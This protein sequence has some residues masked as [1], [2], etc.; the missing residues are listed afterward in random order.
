MPES[1]ERE[2]NS[3][4]TAPLG[5]DSLGPA[6]PSHGVPWSPSAL[7]PAQHQDTACSWTQGKGIPWTQAVPPTAISLFQSSPVLEVPGPADCPHVAPVDTAEVP[8]PAFCKRTTVTGQVKLHSPASKPSCHLPSIKDSS[9]GAQPRVLQGSHKAT[10]FPG[11]MAWCL[12]ATK[13]SALGEAKLCLNPGLHSDT[14]Q[15]E[16]THRGLL[17]VPLSLSSS[18]FST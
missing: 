11:T 4:Y 6:A 17:N 14:K 15:H 7:V 5:K 12:F 8:A 18:T 13:F 3:H 10:R 2:V 1:S 16:N 9:P